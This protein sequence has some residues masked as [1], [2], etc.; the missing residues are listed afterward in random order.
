MTSWLEDELRQRGGAVSFRDFMELALYHPGHGYYTVGPVRVGRDGDYLTAP[1]AS[2]W[3]GRV[4]ADLIS[5]CGSQLGPLRLIDA[6]AGDGS[7][8]DAVLGHLACGVAH[9]TIAVERSPSL[10]DLLA[11]RLS[12]TEILDRL[13]QPSTRPTVLHACELYDALPV[14]RVIQ[15]SKGLRELWVVNRDDGLVWDERE[16]AHQVVEYFEHHRVKL[17]VDQVAEANLGARPLHRELLT[18]AGRNGLSTVIDYGYEAHRL[19]DP[20]GRRGGSLST[21]RDHRMGHDP[22]EAPG[23]Q[24]LTAH[25]NWNDLRDAAADVGWREIALMPL[26]E[27]LVRSGIADVLEATGLGPEAELDART[28]TARQEIKR[29]LD[30]EGMGSDLK[31]LIQASG[32]AHNVVRSALGF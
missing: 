4:L 22:L 10:R 26:A 8:L 31:V 21:F 27:F 25:V 32:P 29:L 6:A 18:A 15:R 1:T 23:E 14:H 28:V 9:E 5:R 12:D 3:Y 24:D 11:R 2:P 7:W 13:R 19:Y 20:R 17:E 16:P 30:P